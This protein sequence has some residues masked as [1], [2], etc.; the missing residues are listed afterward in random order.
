VEL[1]VTACQIQANVGGNLAE[2]LE[3]A[4]EMIRE[5]V[6]LY[7]EINALTA[8]GR[9][10]AGILAALPIFLAL[11]VDRLSPGYLQPLFSTRAG[12]MM[13][14]GASVAM[15]TGLA[16]IKKMLNIQI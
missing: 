8:E 10:S 11:V 3:T 14:G 4:A 16:L 12:L 1:V 2:I 13:L 15:L 9:L 5:R 7:G 6:R